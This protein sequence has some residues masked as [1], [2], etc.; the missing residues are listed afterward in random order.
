MTETI[1]LPG[2]IK[3]VHDI[4]QN[5]TVSGHTRIKYDQNVEQ[6][7]QFQSA[8]LPSFLEP[9][10]LSLLIAESVTVWFARGIAKGVLITDSTW[11]PSNEIGTVNSVKL[12]YKFTD[13][14]VVKYTDSVIRIFNNVY[15]NA[16]G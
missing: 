1:A 12:T 6:S 14:R 16:Y 3:E 8:A 4:S 13:D 5:V 15:D 11:E 2:A 7:F 10:V 9:S